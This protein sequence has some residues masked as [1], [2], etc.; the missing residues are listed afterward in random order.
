MQKDDCCHGINGFRFW[1]DSRGRI[2]VTATP[3]SNEPL[4]PPFV[5]SDVP[6][7]EG[8]DGIAIAYGHAALLIKSGATKALID[9][10]RHGKTP[11]QTS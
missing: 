5:I 1:T 10:W 11:G 4:D 7:P 3:D 6:V 2:H 8:S 9:A